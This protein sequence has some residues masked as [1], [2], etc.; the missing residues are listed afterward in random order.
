MSVNIRVWVLG[1]AVLGE[2]ARCDLVNLTNEV[3]HWVVGKVLHGK[4]A[5]GNVTRVS[6]AEHSVTVTRNNTSGLEGRPEVVLDGLVRE[7]TADRLL[8]FLEPV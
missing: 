6:L 1:L 5:L 8:H 7:I 2:D 4:L 3:E